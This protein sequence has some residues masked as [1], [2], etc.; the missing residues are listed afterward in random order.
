MTMYLP[1]KI[2]DYSSKVNTTPNLSSA[3]KLNGIC[4]ILQTLNLPYETQCKLEKEL[5]ELKSQMQSMDFQNKR[6][7]REKKSFAVLLEKTIKELEDRNESISHTNQ[8]LTTA[9]L[10]LQQTEEE[11]RQSSQELISLNDSLEL[12]IAEA[13]KELELKNKII[14]KKQEELTDSINCAKR[15]QDS[16]LWGHRKNIRTY[17]NGFVLFRPKSIVSGDCYWAAKTGDHIILAAID[18]IGHGVPGAFIS[19]IANDLMNDIVLHEKNLNP[20][21]I[22]GQLNEVVPKVLHQE[23]TN[24]LG[25]MDMGICVIDKLKNTMTYAGAKMPLTYISAEGKLTTIKGS[26]KSIGGCLGNSHKS[27]ENTEIKLEKGT[28]YYLYSDGY[29]DQFGGDA[30]KKFLASKFR[31]LLNNIAH[32]PLSRQKR[33][34]SQTLLNWSKSEEQ[35]DDIL[36]IGFKA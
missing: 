4:T 10:L 1:A 18:C 31:K 33:I 24:N 2:L 15:I 8:E 22:L 32:H 7:E 29:Q 11:L 27:F 23:D 20:A 26:R 13:V 6:L 5:F 21:D 16:I 12:R 34:L 17:L 36:V 25:G 14:V 28:S 19:L 9:N 3:I 35:V 30:G